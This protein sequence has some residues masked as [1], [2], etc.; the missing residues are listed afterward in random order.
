MTAV[1]V[2]RRPSALRSSIHVWLPVVTVLAIIGVWELVVRVGVV[3]E[4]YSPPP[5]VIVAKLASMLLESD[6][7]VALANTLSGW[8]LSLGIS[9]VAGTA[10]GMLLGRVAVLSALFSLIIEFLR[11]IPSIAMIPIA[12]LIMGTA[13]PTEV[14]LAVYA[15]FFQMLVAAMGAAG[16]VDPMGVQTARSFG[17]S[18]WQQ[19]RHVLIPSM[20]P[21]LVTGIRIASSTVLIF[22]ITAELVAGVPGL[23]SGLG[24]ARSVGDTPRMYAYV[25]VIGI[26]GYLLAVALKAIE[27]KLLFWDPSVRS[28]QR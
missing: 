26:V 10:V 25:V 15:G 2:G 9:V 28:V 14:F 17:L 11:P 5:S 3:P 19:A 6:V 21:R 8:G 20:L 22:C 4:R 27:T 7:W 23:G 1:A 18:R 13:R 16:A 12:V 24:A